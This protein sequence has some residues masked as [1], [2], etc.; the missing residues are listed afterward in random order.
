MSQE[1]AT[2]CRFPEAIRTNPVN[3][4]RRPDEERG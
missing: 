2:A 3:P 4:A 1:V